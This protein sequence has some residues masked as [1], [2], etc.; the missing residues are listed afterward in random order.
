VTGSPI[1][2]VNT[3]SFNGITAVTGELL[4]FA[5][6]GGHPLQFYVTSYT[7]SGSTITFFGYITDNGGTISNATLVDKLGT[8]VT[9]PGAGN[10]GNYFT[11]TLSLTPEPNSVVLLGTGL[12]AACG[13]IAVKRRRTLTAT[14]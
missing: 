1:S 6:L 14:I 10:M 4:F 12:L 2:F 7:Y 13:M 3:F 11:G 8:V 5:N 9:G